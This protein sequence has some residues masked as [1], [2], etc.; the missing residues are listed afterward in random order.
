MHALT[1]GHHGLNRP[2]PRS[3]V[4]RA[5]HFAQGIDP[6]ARRIHHA[7]RANAIV[8][9]A[10]GVLRQ[11]TADFSAFIEQSGGRTVVDQQGPARDCRAANGQGQPGIVELSIPVLHATFETVCAYRGQCLP[12]SLRPQKVRFPQAGFTGQHVI[13]REAN[14]V[15]RGFPPVVGRHHKRQR[16]RQMGRIAQQCGALMQGF[17]H[18]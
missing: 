7:A 16:L 18:Q 11:H 12:C 4:G 9:P 3:T 14:A 10:Q 8:L 2:P 17:A 5:V 13:Q 1:G 15:K 6:Y